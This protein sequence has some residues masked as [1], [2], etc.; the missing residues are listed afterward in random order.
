MNKRN[1]IRTLL[2]LQAIIL[3]FTVC[4][5]AQSIKDT[6]KFLNYFNGIENMANYKILKKNIET[7]GAKV[8]QSTS[9][10]EADR[11]ALKDDYNLVKDKSD[12]LVDKMTSDL[13]S[14]PERK[15]MV[16]DPD[17]YVSS[18]NGIFR[19]IKAADSNFNAK[20]IDVFGATRGKQFAYSVNDFKLPLDNAFGDEIITALLKSLISSQLK[21]VISLK[22]WNDL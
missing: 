22:P 3:L 14:T 1:K 18:L 13:L 8:K 12:S 2:L 20:Y 16:K 9:I 17:A 15:K 10:T 7:D 21:K 6:K 4:T 5:S 19:D 11:T